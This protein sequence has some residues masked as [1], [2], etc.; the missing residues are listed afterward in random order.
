MAPLLPS[1]LW[2]L[3]LATATQARPASQWTIHETAT[4]PS[5]WKYV[6]QPD[7]DTTVTRVSISL[8]QPGLDELRRRLDQISDINNAEYGAHLS[9]SQL[10]AYQ[11]PAAEAMQDVMEWLSAHGIEDRLAQKSWVSFNASVGT[12]NSLLKCNLA[13]YTTPESRRVLRTT[14]YSLPSD[15]AHH[16]QFVYPLTQFVES[17][18][19]KNFNEQRGVDLARTSRRQTAWPASCSENVTPDCLV[20]LYNITY[21]PPDSSSG[22]T[23]GVAG[24]LEEYP[25]QSSV[26]DFLV[27]HS[28]RRTDASYSPDYNFNV[29]SINGGNTTNNGSGGE[30]LLDTFYTMPFTQPLPV[31]YLSTGGRGQYIGPNGTDLTNTPANLNEPWLEF[32]QYLLEVEDANLPK[33]L[34]VSYTD[35]E[36]ATP[37]PYALHVCDLFMQ[38]AARGVSVIVASGDGGAAGTA[39]STNCVV[40]SGNPDDPPQFIPTFPASCPYVTSIGAT[41]RYIP[42]E[43]ASFSSGGFSNYFPVPSWQAKDTEAYIKSLNGTHAGWYNASGRG[44]PDLTAVGSRFLLGGEGKYAFTTKGTSASTPVWA[45]IITLINDK[46]LRAGKPVLGFLNPILYSENVRAALTDVASGTIGGCSTN[47]GQDF[48]TGWEAT[49]GWDPSSGLGVPDFAALMEI[50]G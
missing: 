35:D 49:V 42:W 28:P 36:Q 31:S 25:N 6:G 38:L 40:N 48:V 23:L 9:S 33:V 16:I 27:A 29:V 5:G 50:L 21:I 24:F 11:E 39:S 4:V 8:Q 37:R 32:L 44:I 41:G 20:D 34:S 46:R 7:V 26:R 43:P 12:V 15:L 3:L 22:S 17:S 30:A 2:V 45:S 10:A 18:A 1:A 19:R 13:E 14:E 47:G